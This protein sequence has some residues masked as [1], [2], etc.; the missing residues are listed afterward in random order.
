MSGN[1]LRALQRDLLQDL[2]G[3]R[4]REPAERAFD[5]VRPPDGT[6]ESRWHVY[7]HGYVARLVETLEAD[8]PAVRR[9][10]GAA[11]FAALAE[12]YVRAFPPRSFDLGRASA[13]LPEH[14]SVDPIAVALPFLPDLAHL[15]RF[16][17]EAFVAADAEPLTWEDLL[18]ESPEAVAD[19]PLVLAPG[20]ALLP[21]RWPVVSLW[22]TRTQADEEVAVELE[23]NPETAL[24]FRRGHSVAC[25]RLDGKEAA[26]VA[27]LAAGGVT[28]RMLEARLT[29]AGGAAG[30]AS[31]LATFRSIVERGLFAHPRSAGLPASAI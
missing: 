13:L 7:A 9:I 29:P 12:R 24:V 31:L 16:V 18:A 14:L 27:S 11:S 2:N 1:P 28:L 23:R 3:L 5:F 30:V 4:E 22:L 10:L 26:F 20:V 19:L 21:S 8:Y 25:A 15:E 17:A 6:V